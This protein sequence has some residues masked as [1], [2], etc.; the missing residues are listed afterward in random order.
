[1]SALTPNERQ[2]M[3][4]I[5]TTFFGLAADLCELRE[6]CGYEVLAEQLGISADET[7]R[8]ILDDWKATNS[9]AMYAHIL[10]LGEQRIADQSEGAL[11]AEDVSRTI[12]DVMN[13]VTFAAA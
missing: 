12:S 2:T 1:M 8:L 9:D 6:R 5:A 7:R 10:E 4:P 13:R 11:A 3:K